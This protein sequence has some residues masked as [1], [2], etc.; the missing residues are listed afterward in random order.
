[1]Y[2]F[3]R[4]PGGGGEEGRRHVLCS[5]GFG[6]QVSRARELTGVGWRRGAGRG[7]GGKKPLPWTVAGRRRR[8]LRIDKLVDGTVIRAGVDRCQPCDFSLLRASILSTREMLCTLPATG[9][10]TLIFMATSA[11]QVKLGLLPGWG[12]TQLL[13]PL[14]GLQASLDMILTGEPSA[15]RHSDPA[16]HCTLSELL[17]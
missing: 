9:F 12:G 5:K 7:G 8:R 11:S 14:V 4:V 15:T 6:V 3:V 1:M 2:E 17:V 16:T 10:D 13:H